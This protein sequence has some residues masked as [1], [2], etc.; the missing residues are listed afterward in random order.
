MYEAEVNDRFESI[1]ALPAEVVKQ[2]ATL[3]TRVRARTVLPW[4]EHCTECVGLTC[5]PARGLCS[6]LQNRRALGRLRQRDS[7]R[8]RI[9]STRRVPGRSEAPDAGTVDLSTYSLEQTRDRPEVVWEMIQRNCQLGGW[10][11]FATHDVSPHPSLYGWA[12]D[13]L[14]EV[15]RRAAASK[16]KILPIDQARRGACGKDA[17]R[18]TADGAHGDADVR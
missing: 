15:A 13:F 4:G 7:R 16:A 10:L 6:T 3:R 17:V 1:D 8:C 18:T 14:R 5:Y 12:P 2:L 11:I 9:R